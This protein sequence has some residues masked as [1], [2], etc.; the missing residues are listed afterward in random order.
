MKITSIIDIIDGKLLNSPSISFIYSFKTNVSKVKEGDLFIAYN[1]DD[2]QLAIQKGAFAII[3]ENIY[4][5]VDKEIAW[6]KVDS[7]NTSVIKLIRYKLAHFNLEAFFCDE[8]SNEFLKNFSSLSNKKIKIIPKNLKGFVPILEDIDDETILFSSNNEVLDKIYPNNLKFEN[9]DFLVSNLLK[10]SL[11]ETSFTF[12]NKYFQRVKIPSI[13][14]ES[15]I[16]VYNFLDIK[17][18]D[19]S[20]LK[21]IN[22]FKTIF[23]DK[24]FNI[25]EFGKSDKFIITSNNISLV[26]K[27]ISYLKSRFTYGKIIYITS[28]YNEC[29]PKEQIILKDI[30]EIKN[31]FKKN[32]FN[33]SYIFGFDSVNIEENLSKVEKE[34]TLF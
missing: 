11:F 18:F 17:E 3:V 8:I 14:I 12:K 30:S 13:Y 6:I 21:N 4:P 1:L 7:L 33:A 25:V 28:S 22:L 15:F 20:K 2:I 31:I 29:L 26:E 34:L 10:H 9:E 5:I 24:N 27:E 32:S 19:D 16:R 23:L